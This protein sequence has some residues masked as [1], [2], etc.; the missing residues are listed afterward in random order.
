MDARRQH[1]QELP[2]SRSLNNLVSPE[3]RK[4]KLPVK[5][6]LTNIRKGPLKMRCNGTSSLH[7][8]VVK[9][10]RAC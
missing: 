7:R 4:K 10:D 6:L 3:A 2:Q 8:M 5:Q 1:L 9:G